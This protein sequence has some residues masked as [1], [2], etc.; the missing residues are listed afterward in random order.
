ML[1]DP[2]KLM[3]AI[4]NN[5]YMSLFMTTRKKIQIYDWDFF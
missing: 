1:G 2:I 3:V 4:A 5:V